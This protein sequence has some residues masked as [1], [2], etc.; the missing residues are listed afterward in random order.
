MHGGGSTIKDSSKNILGDPKK[1][2]F[3]MSFPIALAL[4][5]QYLNS[6]VDMFWVSGLGADALAAVSIVTPI[7]SVIISIGN[8]IGIGASYAISKLIGARDKRS[9]SQASS[10]ALVLTLMAGVLSIIVL[11]VIVKPLMIYMGAESI[12]VLCI[13]YA[14]PVIIAS[15]LL[16]MGGI[17]AGC[18]RGEGAANRAFIILGIAAV[19]N[20]ILDPILIYWL[21]MGI[22]GAAYATVL[23]AAI[24]MIPVVYW[25]LIKKDVLI[26]IILKGFR[27]LRKEIR[28]IS[29][30]GLPQTI[31]LVFMSLMSVFFVRSISQAGGTDLVAVFEITWRIALILMVPAQAIGTAL[32]PILSASFGMNDKNRVNNIFNYGLKV[33]V[34]IMIVLAVLTFLLA[35]YIAQFMTLSEDSIMLRSS[36]REMLIVCT[37]F[38][39]AFSLIHASA[40]LL[41]S[42]GHGITSLILTVVRNAAIAA[43][44]AVLSVYSVASY[45]W[46]GMTIGEIVFGILALLIAI[47]IFKKYRVPVTI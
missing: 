18:L 25:Y 46:W 32:V 43:I 7:Y 30:V 10:Q 13:N 5:V 2:I 23:S 42:M 44:Y 22:A 20:M 8:G 14:Y 16:M 4:L 36:I 26:P 28:S 33:S 6:I 38:F 35:P 45:M 27:F 47:L 17:F 21:G 29:E 19:F 39:P 37:L 41:Q 40:S 12:L 1:A 3:M 31:E 24:S 11:M 34:I 9:A 15:P